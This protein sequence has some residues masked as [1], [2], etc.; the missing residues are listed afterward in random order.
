MNEPQL[1]HYLCPIC[2]SDQIT[3]YKRGTLEPM[4]AVCGHQF[5]FV[6]GAH[7]KGTEHCVVC[8]DMY[9]RHNR[10]AHA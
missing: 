9:M 3:A 6:D 10:E 2:N 8:E 4:Y 7:V 5:P 1:E